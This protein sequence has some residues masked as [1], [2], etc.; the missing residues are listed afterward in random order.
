MDVSQAGFGHKNNLNQQKWH[1][2]LEW[3]LKSAVSCLLE[4]RH[5]AISRLILG[6]LGITGTVT[7]RHIGV[8]SLDIPL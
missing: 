7:Y 6:Y 2:H 3:K 1:V 4:K 8:L 5:P